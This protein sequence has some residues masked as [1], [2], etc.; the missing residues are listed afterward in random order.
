VKTPESS[1]PNFLTQRRP[2]D[3]LPFP[4]LSTISICAKGGLVVRVIAARFPAEAI[5]LSLPQNV[6]TGS[7]AQPAF[8]TKGTVGDLPLG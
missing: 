5:G 8:C 1:L 6:E 3:R 4:S 2:V 7:G